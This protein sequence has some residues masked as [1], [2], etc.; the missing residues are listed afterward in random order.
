MKLIWLT[1]VVGLLSVGCLADEDEKTSYEGYKLL[2]VYPRNKEQVDLIEELQHNEDFDLWSPK[3][4]DDEEGIKVALSPEAFERY[5]VIFRVFGIKYT[6]VNENLQETFDEEERVMR[7]RDLADGRIAGKYARHTE[8]NN[9]IMT[10]V[11]A[12]PTI[13]SSY[14]AGRTSGNRDMRV[15]VLKTASSRRRIW[16]DCGIHAREWVS[17]STCVWIIDKLISEYR[18]NN[19][20]TV[21]LLQYYEIHVLPVVNPDGYEYSHTTTRLWRKN[22]RSISGSCVGVDLN[23]NYGFQWMTGGASSDP[24]ADTYAGPSR[25]SEAETKAVEAA[26]NAYINTWDAFFTIHAYGKWWFTPYGYTGSSVP[27]D[28]SELRAKAQVGANALMAVYRETGWVTG[29]SAQILYVA[30]GGSDDW[31]YGTAKIKYSH[32][33]ELRPGQTGTDSSYGFTLPEARA[34]LAGEETFQGI[35]AFLNSIKP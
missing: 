33:L 34:P 9:Y 19:A 28:Y 31:A 11:S 12:N 22:R 3:I 29:S 10:Q 25:D 5:T 24:C 15:I 27:P 21:A 14:V 23:R 35:K 26:I 32:C 13:A 4:S 20:V 16:I 7:R 2:D 8:I 17:V 1:L 6:V 30:S 18:A